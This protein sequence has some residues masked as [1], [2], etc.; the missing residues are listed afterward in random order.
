MAVLIN[1]AGYL[2]PGAYAEVNTKNIQDVLSVNALTPIFLTRALLPRLIKR[3][4]RSA[5]IN[6]SSGLGK[7]PIP[8][9]QTYSV[10]KKFLSWFSQAVGL[11]L[12]IEGKVDMLDYTPQQ[13]KTERMS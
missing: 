5:I 7:V 4:E 12:Q 1:N 11:E 6:V 10:S 3:E 9:I 8:G 2:E 13:V